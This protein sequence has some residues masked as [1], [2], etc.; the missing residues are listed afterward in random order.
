[1]MPHPER[2]YYGWQLQEWTRRSEMPK[3]GDGRLIFES[4]INYLMK[5]DNSEGR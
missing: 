2:A 4:M 5:K 3:Y 1:L